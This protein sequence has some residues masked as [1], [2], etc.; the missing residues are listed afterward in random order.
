MHRPEV[1]LTICIEMPLILFIKIRILPI[2]RKL[3]R[4][5]STTCRSGKG[6]K[7]HFMEYHA[8]ENADAWE[9]IQDVLI[10]RVKAG[11]EVR[12]F[13]DDI[14]SISFL[15]HDFTRQLEAL[16]IACRVFNPLF[17]VSIY[18]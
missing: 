10:D 15:N 9:K 18:F 7:I 6:R 12:V 1:F 14:G 8:I 11:V 16:G 17:R 2:T 5:G 13:Y 3:Y 4:T